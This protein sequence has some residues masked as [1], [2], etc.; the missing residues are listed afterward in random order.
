MFKI[1]VT[2]FDIK[3]ILEC[4]QIF[5]FKKISDTNYIVYSGDKKLSISQQDF[6]DNELYDRKYV[7]PEESLSEFSSKNVLLNFDCSEEEFDSYWE[8]YFDLET[9]YSDI[10]NDLSIHGY[11]LCEAMKYG[12]GIRILN[13][14]SFETIIGFIVSAN[15]NISRIQK[16][17]FA[18]SEKYGE[19]KVDKDG[20]QY[21]AFPTPKVLSEISP[22]VLRTECNVGYRD[23]YIV[24]TS[25]MILEKQVDISNISV[26]PTLEL[27]TQLQKLSGIGQKV[28]DCIALFAYSRSE[29]FP[30]DVWTKRV[31]E[32]LFVGHE[33]PKTLVHKKVHEVFGKYAGYAQQYLFYYG[34]ENL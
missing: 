11:H 19:K 31:F 8:K 13:Q 25:K 2:D 14:E 29:V 21:F 12:S 7:V 18:L 34:R 4:G 10:K 27:V 33:L 3:Q 20:I 5:R 6:T 28:A 32:K 15:N 22:E 9:N 23:K 17:M 26:L 16:I 24:N 30:V 1:L